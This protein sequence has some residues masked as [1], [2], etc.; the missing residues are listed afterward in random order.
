MS[1]IISALVFFGFCVTLDAFSGGIFPPRRVSIGSVHSLDSS[2]SLFNFGIR[3]KKTGEEGAVVG[4]QLSKDELEVRKKSLAKP[5]FKRAAT[6]KR[7]TEKP[8]EEAKRIFDKQSTSFNYKKA[9]AFPPLYGGWIEKDGGQIGKQ[10]VQAVKGHIGKSKYMEVLFDPVPNLDEVAFGT[11][12]NKKHRLQVGAALNIPDAMMRG[13]SKVLGFANLYWAN[14]LAVGVGKKTI[15]LTFG[16]EG[17]RE[18]TLP[19]FGSKVTL[20]SYKEAG[21]LEKGEADLLIVVQ[22]SSAGD[23]KTAKVTADRLDIPVVALN[24]P[25]SF[26]YDVGGGGVFDLVYIMKRIPK[27]WIFRSPKFPFEFQAIVE[28][29]DYEMTLGGTFPSQPTL[30]EISKVSAAASEALY[31]KTGNDRIFQNR[32]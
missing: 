31:G 8:K 24:A 26:R 16:N 14:L 11:L 23:Y 5:F 17:M 13:E 30:R 9:G 3:K 27:G 12:N 6:D 7:L 18:K 28:G 29:P 21:K 20:K 19:K 4:R 22:P 10:I 32:L 2:L 25:F 1:M 15:L